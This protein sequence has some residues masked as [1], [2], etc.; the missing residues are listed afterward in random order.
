MK[1]TTY[2]FIVLFVGACN[3]ETETVTKQS[4][5]NET[6]DETRMFNSTIPIAST[7]P[8]RDTASISIASEQMHEKPMVKKIKNNIFSH[9]NDKK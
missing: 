8:I 7:I 2:I 5:L 3:N 4:G 9:Y 1:K 6:A